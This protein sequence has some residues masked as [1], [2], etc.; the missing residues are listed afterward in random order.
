MSQ[1]EYKKMVDVMKSRQGPYAG[2]DISEFYE[3]VQ[4][5]FI[6]EQAQINNVLSRK[7]ASAED[8]AEKLGQDVNHVR[9]TLENMADSGLCGAVA[10]EH[11]TR[12]FGLPFMPGIFEFWFISGREREKDK[13]VANLIHAYKKAYVAAAGARTTPFPVTR[14]IPVN[15]TIRAG[16]TIHT[17]DQVA[18]Y[19]EKYDPVCVGACYC[20]HA[21]KLRGEDIH[22]MPLE[23]CMWFGK[24]AEHFIERMGVRK[25]S[26]QEALEIL[27]RTEEAGLIHMSRNTTD[28]IEFLC[29]C[30]RW[31]C[32]VVTGIMKQPK[33]GMFFNSGYEPVVDPES[34]MSCGTCI[35]R[36]PPHALKMDEN[37][38]NPTLNRDMCFGCGVC[39][40]GCPEGA[41]SMDAKPDFPTPPRD[42][43]ELAAALK[44]GKVE[45]QQAVSVHKDG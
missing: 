10:M 12:Y 35:E 34:C 38:E 18:T 1:D 37:M 3:L 2:M 30:D 43:R 40:T 22:G 15:K 20:R 28:D 24:T 19:I 16:N 27:D 26:K 31:H 13:K 32:E 9:R 7:P 36:C 33:P 41:I 42:L 8:I 17:Y 11:E 39:A 25:V 44:G 45:S 29:N 4:E 14:V 6:P 5:L 21:A 23:V